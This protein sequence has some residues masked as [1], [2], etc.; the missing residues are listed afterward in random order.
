[1]LEATLGAGYG[2]VEKSRILL[3]RATV[4]SKNLNHERIV[5]SSV[6]GI[7]FRKSSGTDWRLESNVTSYL[8]LYRSIDDFAAAI[9][10]CDMN[11]TFIRTGADDTAQLGGSSNIWTTVDAI[12][13]TINTSDRRDKT[14]TQS[15][16][17]GLSTVM[18][19]QPVSYQW[20]DASQQG[21]KIGFIAKD[22]EGVVPEVVVDK[23]VCE[24]P[25]GSASI[26]PAERVGIYYSDLIHVLVNAIQEQ[27]QQ[28]LFLEQ[29]VQQ[30][31]QQNGQPAT[32]R[33]Q[34]QVQPKTG[35]N[36]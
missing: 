26:V 16:N 35:G 13:G 32:P 22:V 5:C 20:K 30:M 10:A 4:F 2:Y 31:E 29:K 36:N 14:A 11:N 18:Q 6:L 21:R 12:N 23:E 8:A 19:L 24:N 25:D 28:I 27:Q 17:Y 3:K 1:L 33:P 34:P 15:I 7:E 9:L